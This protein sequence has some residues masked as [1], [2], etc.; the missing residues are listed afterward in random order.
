MKENILPKRN[1]P[2]D[3]FLHLLAIVTLYWSAVSFVT[4]LWQFI[5]Y[6]FPDVLNYS[7]YGDF[8]G[9]IRFAVSS[10]II[11]FSCFYFSVMVF[12]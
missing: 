8:T 5:N 10:L 1:L 2:R 7:Y 12:E 3:L 11:V 9:V 6:F 4:L